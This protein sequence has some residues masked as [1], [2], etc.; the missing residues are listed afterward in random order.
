MFSIHK[1][2][3]RTEIIR[4][5][6]GFLGIGFKVWG[7]LV[8][9]SAALA[10]GVFFAT[11]EAVEST[12]PTNNTFVAYDQ[13]LGDC[14][15]VAAH[16][17][18]TCSHGDYDTPATS[19]AA[20][21]ATNYSCLNTPS[22]PSGTKCIPGGELE[23]DGTTCTWPRRLC[24]TCR[25]DSGVTKIRVQTNNL[26][27]HCV[28]STQLKEQ[29]FD[30]EVPFNPK[31]TYGVWDV[32]LDT[33]HKLN[34][35]VCRIVKQHDP[36]ALGIVENGDDES[37]NA[38][39]FAL[40]GVAFQFANQIQEDPVFP[41]T[42]ANE[43]PLD[44]CLGHNQ[45]NSPSGMYH[46]HDVSPCLNS[47]FLDDKTMESCKDNVACASDPVA[48]SLSGFTG[49]TK[50][51][52]GIAKDGH[53]L[54][55]PFDENGD[56]WETDEVDACNGAWSSDQDKSDYF[57]VATRWHPYLV[58]CLGP[59]NFPQNDD[60]AL[61]ANCSLNGMDAE[62][63][64]AG[65]SPVCYKGRLSQSY[66]NFTLG[67][68]AFL[69][70]DPVDRVVFIGID[71]LGKRNLEI[72]DMPTLD[73]MFNASLYTKKALIDRRA[74]S[75]ANWQGVLTGYT[76][77]DCGGDG[78]C[79][80]KTIWDVAQ[81]QSKTV[82]MFSNWDGFEEFGDP[83]SRVASMGNVGLNITWVNEIIDAT[84][85]YD[86]TFIHVVDFDLAGHHHSVTEYQDAA[87]F[88]DTNMLRPIWDFVV[89]AG[90]VGVV[91]TADHG[92][93]LAFKCG[94]DHDNGPVPFL[95][96]TPGI[97]SVEITSQ[98]SNNMAAGILA[99]MLGT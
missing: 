43:Q 2:H 71:G 48:W 45:Q 6:I 41:I 85:T 97:T 53:V 58:G 91:L 25:N 65:T 78:F 19:V 50:T 37:K 55:G 80:R 72:V 21:S 73:A 13:S 10:I 14:K 9:V 89:E 86:F 61:F 82:A 77:D 92:T 32:D 7:L 94:S 87:T 59:S 1:H 36:V 76:S 95:A 51:V 22:T 64:D 99:R 57:Y 74:H 4:A 12:S 29:N 26:P 90:N 79:P 38:M 17:A 75:V 34:M 62:R 18:N 23:A 56:V 68:D 69:P 24:V 52:I 54:Y 31:K 16:F 35:H 49:T 39:G 63:G 28:K 84:K 66:A 83:D 8:V 88:Y 40:N 30:Y 98:V 11:S 3:R 42:E 47:A 44:M 81:E 96:Y 60:P 46:Y 70:I 27:D 5:K 33:Q 15:T 93:W 20:M 67:S